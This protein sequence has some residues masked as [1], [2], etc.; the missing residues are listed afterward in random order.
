MK[1]G[2]QHLSAQREDEHVALF[3]FVA[4]GVVH[5]V[6]RKLEDWKSVVLFTPVRVV[7]RHHGHL[8]NAVTNA[9]C[10]RN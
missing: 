3:F 1:N 7:R 2:V 6:I 8:E 4:R 9:R 5:D 10:R